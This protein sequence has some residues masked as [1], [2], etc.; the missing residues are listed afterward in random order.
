MSI[1]VN[2]TVGSQDTKFLDSGLWRRS[3]DRA[4]AAGYRTRAQRKWFQPRH[5]SSRLGEV[6]GI[7]CNVWYLATDAYPCL[8]E[9]YGVD[10]NTFLLIISVGSHSVPKGTG[11]ESCSALVNVYADI[12]MTSRYTRLT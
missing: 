12:A 9:T 4:Q 6:V 1:N 3:S 2:R 5:V 10:E 11:V 7:D 8:H